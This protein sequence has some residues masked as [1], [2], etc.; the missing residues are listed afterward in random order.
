MEEII[1]AIRDEKPNPLP[2]SISVE[3]QELVKLLL[4]KE[5][6]Y[7]PDTKAILKMKNVEDAVHKMLN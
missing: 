4:Q 3:T 2:S 5:P 6:D 7:R 1:F